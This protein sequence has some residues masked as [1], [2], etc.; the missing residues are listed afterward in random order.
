MR[1]IDIDFAKL[2]FENRQY[3]KAKEIFLNN[4]MLYEAGLSS[5]LSGN[6]NSAKL[7]WKEVKNPCPAVGW[8]LI[9][10]DILENKS[11]TSEPRYFQTRAFFEVYLN[12]FIENKLYDWA[13]RIIES[14]K[15]FTHSNNEVPKF[16]ARILSFWGYFPLAHEFAEIS[17]KICW[18][19]PEIHFIEAET[20]LAEEKYNQAYEAIKETLKAA[21]EYYPAK[22]M[23]TMLENSGF[24]L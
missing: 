3:D 20:Y 9:I 16:I 17:K 8:G 1:N 23:K 18:F 5:L 15:F 12:L 4:D 10:L 2:C 7:I 24:V 11:F 22:K 14:Y 19:D 6:L 13:D 21:S